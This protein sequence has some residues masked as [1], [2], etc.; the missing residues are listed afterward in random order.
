MKPEDPVYL[1]HMLDAIVH[2]EN[3]S[4]RITSASELRDYTVSRFL[5][6]AN[7]RCFL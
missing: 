5:Y 7:V 6:E 1:H 4:Q 2:I 3:F